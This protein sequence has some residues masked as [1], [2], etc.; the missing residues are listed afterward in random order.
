MRL[1]LPGAGLAI[2]AALLLSACDSPPPPV[3]VP[4]SVLV[5][6]VGQ[7]VAVPLTVYTGEVRARHETDLSF[8]VGG[9]LV[10]RLVEVG[11]RVRPGQLLARLDP[12]DL[13]LSAE[14]ARDQLVAA[15]AERSLARAELERA[16][17]LLAKKFVSEAVLDSRVTAVDAAE[18]RVRQARAQSELSSNQAAY[19]TLRA[20]QPA[21]V[22]AV[23]A[24]RG[25]VVGAGQAV[26]RTAH[27][28]EREVLIHV[29]EGRIG[30]ISPTRPS[31]RC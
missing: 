14:A 12:Q 20:E 23:L 11:D 4:L 30:S 31:A 25:E 15:E 7:D 17:Q 2:A 6:E 22:L 24:D 21:V 1:D 29:P 10:A 27:E 3:A 13:R 28:T 19:S 8:R 18:A 16:R 5:R 26:L 9:K